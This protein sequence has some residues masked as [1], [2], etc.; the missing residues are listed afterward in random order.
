MIELFLPYVIGLVLG[1]EPPARAAPGEESAVLAPLDEG[2]G[3]AA[4]PAPEPQIATGK[5]TTAIEVKP[6][7]GMTKANWVAVRDYEGQDLLYFTHLLSWRCGLWDISYGLN[8]APPEQ[9][10]AMEP[11]HE[12]TATPNAMSDPAF[13]PYIALPPGSVESIYVQVTFDDGTGDFARFE[14]AQI[15]IP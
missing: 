4:A 6:I 10:V 12:D 8:G 11:C 7:L 3:D 15:E 5:F 2:S 1:I 13:Q 14:R 9:V